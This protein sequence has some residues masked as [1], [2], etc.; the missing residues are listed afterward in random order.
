MSLTRVQ[1]ETILVKRCGPLLTAA[2][3]ATTFAGANTDLNDPIG[4]AI[5]KSGGTVTAI[6][7]VVDA[8]IATIDSSDHDQLL[9]LAELRTLE[10]ILGN[11]DDVDI[12]VG[13]RDEKLSQLRTDLEKRL[14]RLQKRI[15]DEYGVTAVSMETGTI[16][17]DFADHNEPLAE[18]E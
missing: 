18:S 5:R 8:D 13:P 16:A 4:Y 6:T 7:A 1:V 12:R 9:D 17:L 2:G 11:L 10:T 3:M 14:A 15:Q